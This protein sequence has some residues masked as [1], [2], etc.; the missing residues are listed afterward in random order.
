LGRKKGYWAGETE[1]RRK[2]KPVFEKDERV[3]DWREQYQKKFA[4]IRRG[5]GSRKTPEKTLFQS[6]PSNCGKKR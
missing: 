2:R 3:E 4:T 6:S 5:Q 1:V